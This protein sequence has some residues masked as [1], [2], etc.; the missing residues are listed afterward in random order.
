[1]ETRWQAMAVQAPN[2]WCLR[3][4][5]LET[6]QLYTH[7]HLLWLQPEE[8][9]YKQV[10]LQQLHQVTVSDI[11][12]IARHCSSSSLACLAGMIANSFSHAFLLSLGFERYQHHDASVAA[13]P[14][15]RT[16]WLCS[17]RANISICKLLC[18]RKLL[19]A[20]LLGDFCLSR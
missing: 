4:L 19:K 20:A 5:F 11:D 10:R 1:M 8:D 9:C 18:E 12:T 15:W 7:H 13:H 17:Q 3:L 16:V 6:M 2:P 14:I